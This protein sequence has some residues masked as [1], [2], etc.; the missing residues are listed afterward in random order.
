MTKVLTATH[1]TVDRF[2][3][4][5]PAINNSVDAKAANKAVGAALASARGKDHADSAW[6]ICNEKHSYHISVD[7]SVM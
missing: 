2:V 6:S 1:V 4:A 5:S 3:A 7:K